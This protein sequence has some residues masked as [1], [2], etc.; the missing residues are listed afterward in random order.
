MKYKKLGTS[1]LSVS[2]ICLGT[3]TWGEQNSEAEAHAQM[4]YALAQ[5]VNFF[6]T[7]ELYPVPPKPETQGLTEAYIGTWFKRTGRREDVVLA[8][9]VVG[10]SD[11]AWFR[12]EQARLSERHIFEAV[13]S[14]LKKLQ[15]DYIDLYQLHWPDRQ[16]N[17]FGKLGYEHQVQEDEIALE[18]TLAACK[19]LVAA[20][21]IREIGV[22]NET[23]WGLTEYLRLSA[24]LDLPRVQ[25]IQNPYNLLNRTF[26]IGLAEVACRS[27]AGL[28]AY[29]PLAMGMLSG[30]YATKP[31]PPEAR[32]SIYKRFSRYSSPIGQAT[33]QRYVDV[34]LHHGLDPSQMALAWINRQ[35]F[36]T[37]NIIGAT[38]LTQLKANID[39]V[40]LQLSDDVIRD[41]QAIHDSQSNPCP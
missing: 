9:K 15:T 7:A 16:T 31:W 22:S 19:A 4:D 29:S 23:P 39:S 20:G 2:E 25:S 35:P 32:L 40:D 11:M 3:M 28:L 10:R 26:E 18:T 1:E 13:D 36:V 33:A 27:N 37:S 5:G 41:I 6:D 34:A 38:N 14:S 21:K 24:Q 17:T 8:T 30:K 12:G